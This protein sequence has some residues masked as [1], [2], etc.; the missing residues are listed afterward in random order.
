MAKTKDKKW[1]RIE[2]KY[3]YE[4]RE[5][6]KKQM[7]LEKAA[8]S[9]KI[10][11]YELIIKELII[12][13]KKGSIT[14]NTEEKHK[15]DKGAKVK[16]LFKKQEIEDEISEIDFEFKLI[17]INKTKNVPYAF[18]NVTFLETVKLK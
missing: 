11:V 13:E 17:K 2:M 9:L 5:F 10:K 16:V 7:I 18:E 8:Y 6:L 1:L 3:G 15:I 4:K 14:F 12:T